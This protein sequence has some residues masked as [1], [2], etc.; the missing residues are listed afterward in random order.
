MPSGSEIGSTAFRNNAA[1]RERVRS[2]NIEQLGP[3]S[4]TPPKRRGFGWR[5]HRCDNFLTNLYKN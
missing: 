2:S 4:F 3:P 1:W 5:G